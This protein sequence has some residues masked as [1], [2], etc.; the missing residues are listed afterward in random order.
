MQSGNRCSSGKIQPRVIDVE[1]M[2][3]F[4]I[5]F[6][7]ERRVGTDMEHQRKHR[8][9]MV[10]SDLDGTLLSSDGTITKE[11][12]DAVRRFIAKGNRFYLATGRPYVFADEIRNE[13]SR[14][15]GVISYNG[16]C[17]EFS[18]EDIVK[19]PLADETLEVVGEKLK[20]FSGEVYFKTFNRIY[21]WKAKSGLFNYPEDMIPTICIDSMEEIPR[22]E[23]MLKMLFYSTKA[24]EIQTLREI[25]QREHRYTRTDYGDLGFE[26]ISGDHNKGT[27]L[28]EVM[29]RLH[30]PKEEVLAVGDGRNDVDLFAAAGYR[31]SMGNGD[32]VLKS[33][34]DEEIG[35]HDHGGIAKLLDEIMASS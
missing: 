24:E 28:T 11:N 7:H 5:L 22:G 18:D 19:Y 17:I 32:D 20:G 16:A 6:L 34:A 1:K 29:K 25:L 12:R 9:T 30:V 15:V 35:H 2:G 33:L 14:E 13:I 8:I 4:G 31:V 23:K 10:V 27:A 21:A 3:S 26:I